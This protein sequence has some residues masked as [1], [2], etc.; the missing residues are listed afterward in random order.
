MTVP[1]SFTSLRDLLVATDRDKITAVQ[2]ALRVLSRADLNTRLM[3]AKTVVQAA[4][5]SGRRVSKQTRLS[6]WLFNEECT[7]R[8]IP[9]VFR[10]LAHP[11]DDLP[12][13]VA[14]FFAFDLQWLSARYPTHQPLS[15]QWRGLFKATMFQAAALF[16]CKGN[17]PRF[18][19]WWFC[20]RLSL[21]GD[22]Q[23][24]MHLIKRATYRNE[25]D[26]LKAE[27]PDVRVRLGHAYHA[28]DSRYKTSDHAA[29][30]NRRTNIWFVGSLADWKPQ[31][32]A[33]LYEAHTGETISRQQVANVISQ[34]HRDV[35]EA[36][37]KR[38]R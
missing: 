14:D 18:D 4:S 26:R 19:M 25:V 15:K 24:E 33:N 9:P 12:E 13:Q 10:N 37:P 27:L 21:T 2:G 35:P 3:R 8:G 36:K 31:R 20:Q 32:T 5:D 29:T 17:Y 34:I 22:Q 1:A 30:I 16:V 28:R 23:R 7:R 6:L 11:S 38:K